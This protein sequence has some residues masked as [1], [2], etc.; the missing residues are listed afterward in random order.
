VAR[1][2]RVGL[3]GP[4]SLQVDGRDVP[5]G[6]ARRRSA[7]ALLS[8]AGRA[9][10]SATSLAGAMFGD[11]VDAR[12]LNTLQVHLSQ[13]R[14]QL[15]PYQGA[16]AR[17]GPSYRLDP[18]LVATDTD[19]LER[20][21]EQ[22]RLGEPGA[23]TALSAAAG[24]RRGE[25]CA[26]LPDLDALSGPRA[27][28]EQLY[29]DA[30]EILFDAELQSGAGPHLPERIEAVVA[31]APLRE[32][33]WAQ[34]MLAL[35]AVGRQT[36]ALDAYRR[37]RRVLAEEVGVEP[38]TALRELEVQILRQSQTLQRRVP[39]LA[40]TGNHA[41]VWLEPSGQPRSVLLLPGR[42]VTI[43]R[44]LTC[45][46]RLGWDP[47]V[48][49]RHAALALADGRCLVR[50]LGSRN[51]TFIDELLVLDRAVLA[52]GVTMRTGDS[53]LFLRGPIPPV[54]TAQA[55]RSVTRVQAPNGRP[56]GS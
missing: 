5:I 38:G 31:A 47:A 45:T 19:A 51:G 52:P 49:R 34:L 30:R 56:P 14:G 15:A 2:V 50:D 28:Y 23:V 32:R 33:L 48:S 24:A 37:A 8:L 17:V 6:G 42:E 9:G 26:D 12:T 13:L 22:W 1:P 7:L 35:Y 54:D 4:V 16:L 53:M 3:L 44:D 46:I 20:A 11:A 41:V 40:A 43:G 10:I 55:D 36:A 25:L 27:H 29:L 21:L 18:D 39:A